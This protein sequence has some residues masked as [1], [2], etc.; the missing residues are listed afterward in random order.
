M[1]EQFL[2][3]MADIDEAGQALMAG[4]YE[5][6]KEKGFTGKQTPGAP[7]PHFHGHLPLGT[8]KRGR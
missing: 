7:L 2:T 8:G 4:W 3:L 1:A 6:L 5:K